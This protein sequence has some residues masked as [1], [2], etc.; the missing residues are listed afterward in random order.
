MNTNK[1]WRRQNVIRKEAQDS[2]EFGGQ[3]CSEYYL[4]SLGRWVLVL[5]YR[6]KVSFLSVFPWPHAFLCLSNNPDFYT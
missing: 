4:M 6:F 2:I 1:N 3:S 5:L